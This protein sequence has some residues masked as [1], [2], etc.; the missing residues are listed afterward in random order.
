MKV[1]HTSDW[2]IGRAL[3]GHKRYDEYKAFLNRLVVFI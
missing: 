2:R 3:S 1:L